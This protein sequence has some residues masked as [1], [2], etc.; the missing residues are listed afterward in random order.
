MLIA[1]VCGFVIGLLTCG[2]GLILI[3]PL[4]I[5]AGVANIVFV[6]VAAIAANRGEMYRY[7]MCIRLVK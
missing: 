2:F 1:M 4:A 5:L 7:P 3:L 6:I